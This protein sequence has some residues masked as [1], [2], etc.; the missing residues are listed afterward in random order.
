MLQ[1]EPIIHAKTQ[2][3]GATPRPIPMSMLGLSETIDRL[4]M[5]NSVRWYGHELRREDSHVLRMAFDFEV[6]VQRM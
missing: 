5:T 6:E 2:E 3:D 1:E 4:P